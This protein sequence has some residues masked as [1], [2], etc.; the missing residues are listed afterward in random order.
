MQRF[1]DGVDKHFKWIEDGTWYSFDEVAA[2]K[3]ALAERKAFVKE[4]RSKGYTVIV[5]SLGRQLRRKGGIG[6]NNPDIEFFTSG[7][8]ANVYKD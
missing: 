1:F 2:R 7:L 8:Y 6:T 3:T 4:M 5:G